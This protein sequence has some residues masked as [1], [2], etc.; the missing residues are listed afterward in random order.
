M[1]AAATHFFDEVG[2]DLHIPLPALGSALGHLVEQDAM[3][4]TDLLRLSDGLMACRDKSL[5]LGGQRRSQTFSLGAI[6]RPDWGH[7]PPS[8]GDINAEKTQRQD[9]LLR[10]ACA[11]FT[12]LC[13]PEMPRAMKLVRAAAIMSDM[14][15]AMGNRLTL[16]LHR[17]FLVLATA[18]QLVV[19]GGDSPNRRPQR[20]CAGAV[21]R[22]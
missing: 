14:Q 8:S 13:S 22:H 7:N 6:R 3:L 20:R 2:A 12:R 9:A 21:E 11:G 4:F 10:D 16:G 19:A 18:V 15:C 1:E 5:Q 17:S